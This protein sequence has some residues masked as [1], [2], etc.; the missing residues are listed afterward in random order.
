MTNGNE[1]KKE[2]IWF[3]GKL[4]PHEEAKIHV[5]SHVIHYG[6][7][8]FE[9]IRLYENEK[10]SCIFRLDEHIKR[11]INSC[12]I[13]H[14]EPEY[15]V[16]ELK[17]ATIDTLHANNLK[18]AYIRPIVFRGHG[19][20]GIN[21]YSCPI[22]TVIAAWN[23]GAYLGEDAL[24]NGIS[25]CISSWNKISPNTLPA[26]AK[27]CGN[28]LNSQLMKLEAIDR[29][30]D[31]AIALDTDGYLSEGSG[32]NLFFI[33]DDTIYTPCLSNAILDGITRNAV[34]TIIKDLGI[35][36]VEQR[37]PREMI[38]LSDE[39]FFTGTAAEITPIIKVDAYN[40]KDGRVGDITKQIQEIFFGII[41]AKQE[42]KYNWLSYI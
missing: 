14:L 22:E 33:K 23:W 1:N 17:Q 38:Y 36:I 31:E 11:L 18:K 41:N 15:T 29:G 27:A 21:P 13:Y 4:V 39:A 6:T 20:L 9:G 28:Y 3:N 2:L 7:G 37:L 34:V 19:S 12:K 16:D 10:G 8:A 24:T 30:Y 32:E 25:A 42:D 35:K 40:I 5:L 26:L